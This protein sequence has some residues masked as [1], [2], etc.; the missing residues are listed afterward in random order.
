MNMEAGMGDRFDLVDDEGRAQRRRR[1]ILVSAIAAIVV[2]IAAY[3]LTHRKGDAKAAPDTA[4]SV[5][6]IVPRRQS[7]ASSVAATGNIA[8]RRDMPVG[9][10]GEGG[11]VRQ[12]FVEPGDWVK[13]GQTLATIDRS[14][15]TQQASALA[16]AIEQARADSALA[17][18]NLDRA[19]KLVSNG[20]VSKA[21][22]DTK[23]AALDGANARVAV[24]QAQ[25]GQQR[26]LIGRLDI[27]A[28]TGGLVLTRAVEAGQIVGSGSGGLF[29]VAENGA[30]EVRT[31]LAEADLARLRIGAPATVTP[32]GTT[33]RIVGH[34]WQISPVIDPNTRQGMVRVA[35]PFDKALRPG[36]FASVSLGGGNA[37]VPLLPESAVL[38]D[39]NGNFVYV[40][41]ADNHVS[42]R[43]V[44]V[45]DVDDR[46]VSVVSGLDGS[47]RVIA[48]AGAFLNPGDKVTPTLAK[49]R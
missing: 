31:S 45:G 38:S 19:K 32:V 27:R 13:Q 33:L 7:I 42:R 46:G 37:D 43:P 18:A 2:V 49:T 15:Q 12:V 11:V 24:A 39:N 10:A 23:Q 17:R 22:I 1:I 14:V 40:V 34:V 9:V 4:P 26:A 44:K 30:M 5:T 35:L 8:A 48:S 20:F 28:P 41:G 6:V 47:E 16:A 29:R 3:V 36:G 25:L 21:D